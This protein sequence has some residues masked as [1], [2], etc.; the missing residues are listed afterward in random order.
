MSFRSIQEKIF[1]SYQGEDIFGEV[2]RAQL[3]RFDPV[4]KQLFITMMKD[5]I[6]YHE[7][8]FRFYDD[9][10]ADKASL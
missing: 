6:R 5:Y 9:Y 4:N 2:D 8:N 3:D 10:E 7:N 1:P